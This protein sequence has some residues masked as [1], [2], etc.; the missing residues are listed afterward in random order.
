MHFKKKKEFIVLFTHGTAW[1]I[2]NF[3]FFVILSFN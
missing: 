2:A 1:Q 3:W